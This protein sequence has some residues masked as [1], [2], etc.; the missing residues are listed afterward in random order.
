[1]T[2]L[3]QHVNKSSFL[4]SLPSVT[5]RT[6]IKY[7]PDGPG[8]AVMKPLSVISIALAALPLVCG[9]QDPD[10][11]P[12]P[13]VITGTYRGYLDVNTTSINLR[14]TG[15]NFTAT[16]GGTNQ[17]LPAALHAACIRAERDGDGGGVYR[18]ADTM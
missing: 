15:M 10:P 2:I 14:R 8:V 4:T 18:K 6:I 5:A 16:T 13:V 1:M 12:D 7:W 17:W 3:L 11:Y 9:H